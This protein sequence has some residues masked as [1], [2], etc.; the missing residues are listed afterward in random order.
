MKGIFRNAAAALF[1][2]AGAISSAQ[3]VTVNPVPYTPIETTGDMFYNNTTM[4]GYFWPTP[5]SAPAPVE[6]A[7]DIPFSGSRHVNQFSFAYYSPTLDTISARVRF[8]SLMDDSG[9]PL[10]VPLV[11]FDLKGLPAHPDHIFLV[12]VDL[13]ADNDVSFDLDS[14]PLA[15]G[16]QGAF[17]GVQFSSRAAGWIMADGAEKPGMDLFYVFD[18]VGGGRGPGWFFYESLPKNEGSF[19]LI[20]DGPEVSAP[21]VALGSAQ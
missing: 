15:S 13:T 3:V 19:Y 21:S 7:D 18:P 16:Q 8:Y 1:L 4:A 10:R 9:A 6:V 5:F 14:T 2:A 12:N 17:V 11:S 20:L